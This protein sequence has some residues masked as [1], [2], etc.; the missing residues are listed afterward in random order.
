MVTQAD[1]ASSPQLH[2]IGRLYAQWVFNFLVD[3]AC[4]IAD[5]FA[6]RPQH[7]KVVP[8]E[9][10]ATLSGF[11]YLLGSHPDWPDTHQRIALFRTLGGAYLAGIPLR[12]AALVYVEGGTQLNHDLLMDAFRDSAT[13]L[14]NQ[15]TEL[16]GESLQFGCRQINLIFGNAVRL[17]QS[18]EI[19]RVFNLAAAPKQEDWPFA[20]GGDGDRGGLTTELIRGLDAGVVARLLVGGPGREV[21]VPKPRPIRVSM[22]P[23]KFALLQQAARYGALAIS[24]TMAD[25]GLQGDLHQ[26]IGNTYKWTKALQRLIPDVVRA[27]KDPNYRMRLTDLE[28]GMIE[29]HP[30][31]DVASALV[32]GG[33]GGGGFSTA[34]IRGE[35]CCST[36]DLP[37]P[38]SSNCEISPGPSC[39]NCGSIALVRC[40]VFSPI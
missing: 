39:I 40:G 31:G 7:Y 8:N 25:N 5:D 6:E 32:G 26:M 37:C 24:A 18:D 22:T 36:G 15:I 11:R 12:E 1:D 19:M 20:E 13:S 28:W 29:P 21:G 38:S 30:S 2:P 14:R 35:V 9:V 17:L 33:G 27:W 16:S 10:S 34:T 23:T 4:A 3:I